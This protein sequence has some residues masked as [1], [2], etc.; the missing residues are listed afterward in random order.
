MNLKVVRA[1]QLLLIVVA[2]L[3]V[4]GCYYV[5]AARGQLEINRKRAAIADVVADAGTSE[6]LA[7]QLQLISEA[8]QFSIDE[9]H[10]PDNDSYRSYADL[11]RDFV[12]W[13]TGVSRSGNR[14]NS[15]RSRRL[16][17]S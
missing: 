17:S 15:N 3:V 5:Q 1:S 10:L 14:C 13:N 2:M 11:E 16:R 6:S 8:R 12:V 4:S 9:L 7:A